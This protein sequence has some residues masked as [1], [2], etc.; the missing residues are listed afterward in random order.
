MPI[1]SGI[2]ISLLYIILTPSSIVEVLQTLNLRHNWDNW[3]IVT[4][5]ILLHQHFDKYQI[6]PQH[7]SDNLEIISHLL[8]CSWVLGCSATIK[9]HSLEFGSWKLV[10]ILGFIVTLK[11]FSLY[12]EEDHRSLICIQDDGEETWGWRQQEAYGMEDRSG[13]WGHKF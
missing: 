2:I 12:L 8:D 4:A 1:N 7:D 5:G 9:D 11:K 3:R 13:V 6:W 10:R